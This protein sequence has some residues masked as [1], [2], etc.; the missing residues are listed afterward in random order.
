MGFWKKLFR[1]RTDTG[2][3]EKRRVTSKV[4]S[5]L[6]PDRVLAGGLPPHAIAGTLHSPP[7]GP[8][9]FEENPAFV[10]LLHQVVRECAP[11]DPGAQA[12]AQ[13]IGN[14][15]LYIVDQRRPPGEERVPP[16][17]IIGYFA[18]Q[19]GRVTAEGYTPNAG[20]RVFSR[21]GLVRLPGML[22]DVLVTR[23]AE[24]VRG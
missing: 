4:I 11:T 10:A 7:E 23:A 5:L 2:G 17:D 9:T 8:A 24:D 18:V 16:E 3:G 14:G 6:P 1:K 13:R 22:Q 12:E 15:W 19:S 21:L 20:Y